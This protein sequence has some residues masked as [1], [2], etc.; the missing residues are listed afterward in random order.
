MTK[1][2]IILNTVALFLFV[3]AA[4]GVSFAQYVNAQSQNTIY[5]QTPQGYTGN[6]GFLSPTCRT[7]IGMGMMGRF[8]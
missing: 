7:G 4:T 6:H 2:K 8:W 3:M 5:N 1:T